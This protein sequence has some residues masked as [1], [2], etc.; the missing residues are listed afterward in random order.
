[1]FLP[2]ACDYIG[3]NKDETKE[4][5]EPLDGDLMNEYKAI[6]RQH[7]VW[8]SVGGFHERTKAP[9]AQVS[10]PQLVLF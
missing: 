6:A 5:S 4:L 10:S 7:S 2:E 9:G 8:L 3:T 1:M